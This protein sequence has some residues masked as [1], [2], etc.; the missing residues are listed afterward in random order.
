MV[1]KQRFTFHK[2]NL[3]HFE[4]FGNGI[5]Y[6][7]NYER[8]LI[9]HFKNKLSIQA[10][11]CFF[12]QRDG[13]GFNFPLK[14]NFLNSFYPERKHHMELGLGLMMGY[15]LG[16]YK[17]YRYRTFGHMLTGALGYRFQKPQGKFVFKILFTPFYDYMS[18][19][20]PVNNMNQ[21]FAALKNFRWYNFHPSGGISVGYGF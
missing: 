10:G 4:L 6:S 18:A 20:F 15:F 17:G 14:F 19:G 16:N 8:I 9:N 1:F 21:R 5:F 7:F 11:S 12:P 2:K 3:V 13:N